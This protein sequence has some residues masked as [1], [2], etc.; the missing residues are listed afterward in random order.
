[1]TEPT[2]PG[3]TQVVASKFMAP[4][5][6]PAQ[7]VP[8]LI[9]RRLRM[10]HVRQ[11]API[12]TAD[13]YVGGPRDLVV[14]HRRTAVCPHAGCRRLADSNRRRPRDGQVV[15]EPDESGSA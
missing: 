4:L 13:G 8:Q 14:V 5:R 1:M 7:F 10:V 3:S 15:R 12:Q 2:R 11:R 6:T 9:V